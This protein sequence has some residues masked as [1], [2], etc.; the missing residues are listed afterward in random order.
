M[1]RMSRSRRPKVSLYL[2]LAAVNRPPALLHYRLMMGSTL[3]K[4]L[5][6]SRHVRETRTPARFTLA[7]AVVGNRSL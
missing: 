5:G 2:L 3:R 6:T 4:T 7:P 1:Q